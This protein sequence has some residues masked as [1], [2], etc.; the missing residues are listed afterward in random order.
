MISPI[1]FVQ[2]KSL[3]LKEAETTPRH[4][5]TYLAKCIGRFYETYRTCLR[6]LPD[7]A[8]VLSVGAGGAYVE[9][10]LAIAHGAR[11]TVVDFPRAIE[12]LGEEY[13]RLGFMTLGCDLAGEWGIENVDAFDLVLSCE[14]LEHLPISPYDHFRALRRYLKPGAVLIVTT[15]NL[16]SFQN[17]I[18]LMKGRSIL[19]PAA[20][21]FGPVNYGHEH[22][23]RRIYTAE[24]VRCDMRK[25]GVVPVLTIYFVERG[26][27]R[28]GLREWVS[29][30]AEMIVPKWREQ[31]IIAGRTEGNVCG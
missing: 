8:G 31:L 23:H 9:R 3:C 6:F 19:P 13:E 27:N 17:I 1:S 22:I 24:E 21:V 11:L 29:L 12:R 20:E 15:P 4:D 25:S 18:R 5:H 16:S 2:F 28:V 26:Y 7:N 30:A 10:I 14:V